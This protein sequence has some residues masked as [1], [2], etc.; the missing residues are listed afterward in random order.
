MDDSVLNEL[1]QL[2]AARFRIDR[3]DGHSVRGVCSDLGWEESWRWPLRYVL[4]LWWRGDPGRPCS[5]CGGLSVWEGLTADSLTELTE[6]RYRC[7]ACGEGHGV[8]LACGEDL[9]AIAALLERRLPRGARPTFLRGG[10]PPHD[11]Q[12]LDLRYTDWPPPLPEPRTEAMAQTHFEHV[13]ARYFP[14]AR[15]FRQVLPGYLEGFDPDGTIFVADVRWQQPE[16]EFRFAIALALAMGTTG[17]DKHNAKVQER[18]NAVGYRAMLLEDFELRQ[19][20]VWCRLPLV[21]PTFTV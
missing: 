21:G 18:I 1:R 4:K 13:K 3:D 5:A 6:L 14:R 7:L 12:R 11:D 2:H 16:A 10:I 20:V 17:S 8:P 15:R 19:H 9:D